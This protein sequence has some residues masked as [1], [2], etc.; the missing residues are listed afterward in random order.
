MKRRRGQRPASPQETKVRASLLAS[1]AVQ[2]VNVA[3]SKLNGLL[4]GT[5]FC[6]GKRPVRRDLVFLLLARHFALVHGARGATPF[7]SFVTV[8]MLTSPRAMWHAWNCP[9]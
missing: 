5:F 1:I 3:D 4:A 2:R 6:F 8:L 9:R 7:G